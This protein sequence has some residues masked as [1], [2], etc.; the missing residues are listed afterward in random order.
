MNVSVLNFDLRA[1][2]KIGVFLVAEAGMRCVL[3][4]SMCFRIHLILIDS[5]HVPGASLSCI[6][7]N[8]AGVPYPKISAVP[9]TYVIV[10]WV[11]EN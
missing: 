6:S 4:F 1:G 7:R 9:I 5:L 8:L 10:V 2:R 11:L 3:H